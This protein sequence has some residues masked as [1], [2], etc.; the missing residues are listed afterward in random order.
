V[1]I[2]ISPTPT[3]I[4]DPS[5]VLPNG[6]TVIQ[7]IS[8]SPIFNSGIDFVQGGVDLGNTQYIDAYQRG[9]FWSNVSTNTNYHALLSLIVLP[10]VHRSDARKLPSHEEPCLQ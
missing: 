1:R 3:G 10:E 8:L 9:N 4:F 5:H 2:V 7:N 6:R